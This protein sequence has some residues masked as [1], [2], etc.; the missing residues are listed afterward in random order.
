MLNEK[1][2]DFILSRHK[3]DIHKISEEVKNEISEKEAIEIYNELLEVLIKHNISYKC[4]CNIAVSLMY[5]FI[6]GAVE[7][8]EDEMNS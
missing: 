6:S 4:G 8:Y 3:K 5:A 7:L 1:D 2:I